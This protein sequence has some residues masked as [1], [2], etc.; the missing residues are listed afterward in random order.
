MDPYV[1]EIRLFAGN[2]APRGWA[3]CHGQQLEIRSNLALY[4]VI[5]TTY[6]GDGKNYFQLPDLRGRA[7]MHFGHGTGLTPRPLGE[8]GGEAAVTLTTSQIPAHVHFAGC[9]STADKK[10]PEGMIWANSPGGKAIVRTYAETGT[11]KMAAQAISPAG[12]GQ[13]HN[14]M[15]PYLA[16]NFIIALEGIFPP[17]S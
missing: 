5:G 1:G 10:N 11:V 14:N 9:Q 2:Y 16:I 3:F 13:P 4:A 15:Q 12:G 7:P 17:R 6:G 8:A